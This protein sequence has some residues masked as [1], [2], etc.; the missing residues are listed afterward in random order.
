MVIKNKVK[1]KLGKKC[2]KVS[3]PRNFITSCQ[4]LVFFKTFNQ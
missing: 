3:T 2:M 1:Q 4:H